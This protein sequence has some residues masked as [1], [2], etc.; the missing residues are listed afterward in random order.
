[1]GFVIINLHINIEEKSLL[2]FGEIQIDFFTLPQISFLFM[3]IC[4]VCT[5]EISPLMI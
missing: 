5:P 3:G 4:Q 1:M 2:E